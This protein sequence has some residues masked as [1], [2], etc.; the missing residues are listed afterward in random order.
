[1]ATSVAAKR[2]EAKTAH[3]TKWICANL[4]QL[5]PSWRPLTTLRRTR[6]TA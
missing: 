1:V 5:D 2:K 4:P 3:R 6:K